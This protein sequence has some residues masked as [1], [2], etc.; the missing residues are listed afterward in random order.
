MARASLLRQFRRRSRALLRDRRGASLLEYGAIA[1]MVGALSLASLMAIGKQTEQKFCDAVVAASKS[2]SAE[3]PTEAPQ[4]SGNAAPVFTTG[5]N[6][7]MVPSGTVLALTVAATDPEGSSVRYELD[8]DAPDWLSIS[9]A[10]GLLSERDRPEDI[11][12]VNVAVRAIDSQGAIGTR[13]FS[14]VYQAPRHCEDVR[15]SGALLSASSVVEIDPDQDALDPLRV[16]CHMLTDGPAAG[17]WT[18]VAFQ[19]ADAPLSDWNAGATAATPEDVFAASFALSADQI[20]THQH[21]AFGRVPITDGIPSGPVE[22]LDA[23]ALQYD[24]SDIT[25][26]RHGTEAGASDDGNLPGL[27]NPGVRYDVHRSTASAFPQGDPDFAGAGAAASTTA[28]TSVNALTFDRR[29][30]TVVPGIA[31]FT[32]SFAPN[33]ANPRDTGYAYGGVR[34][35]TDASDFAWV[36][37]VK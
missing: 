7:G 37:L 11:R 15:T 31:E 19:R 14:F 21:V 29:P 22:I 17:G 9:S 12:A 2:S 30:V 20:P 10:D 26:V 23:V 24:T 3:C 6:L 28:P 1:A 27:I 33:A 5:A 25:A 8:A 4:G 35:T 13:T 16:Y 18:M 32:W 34:S 36:V